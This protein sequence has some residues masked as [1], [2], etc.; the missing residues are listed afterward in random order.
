M[1]ART[2]GAPGGRDRHMFAPA[3][4]S[5]RPSAV[6]YRCHKQKVIQRREQASLLLS[7]SG[8]QHLLRSMIQAKHINNKSNDGSERVGDVGHA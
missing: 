8:R 4:L 5:V 6:C 3:V 2:P 7:C 1:A